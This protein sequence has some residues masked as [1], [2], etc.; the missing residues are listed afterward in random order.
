MHG[1]DQNCRNAFSA[2]HLTM[3]ANL[4]CVM[5]PKRLGDGAAKLRAGHMRGIIMNRHARDPAHEESGPT[6]RIGRKVEHEVGDDEGASR[7]LQEEMFVNLWH[8]IHRQ[9]IEFAGPVGGWKR[10][11]LCPDAR[12]GGKTI[13]CEIRDSGKAPAPDPREPVAFMNVFNSIMDRKF[14]RW[15]HR[16]AM[17]SM[18]VW[19]EKDRTTPIQQADEW[20]RY[21]PGMQFHRVP[22]AGHL[23]LDE[24][25]E[26]AEAIASFL[27]A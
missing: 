18:L 19:G 2:D 13:R 25:P 21:V 11:R 23:L 10:Q 26:V 24:K 6:G 9:D 1:I 27:N 7:P 12:G 17:P 20:L 15:L 4:Q 22:K 5:G 14:T 3:R 16:L 8:A